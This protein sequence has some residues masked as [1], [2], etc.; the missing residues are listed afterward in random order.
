MT[1]PPITLDDIVDIA[2]YE[3]ERDERRA[4][5]MAA[6]GVRRVR[7]GPIVSAAF[8]NRATVIYQI[9]EM[10]RAE[11]IVHDDAIRQEIDVYSETLP[12]PAELSVTLFIELQGDAMLREW[13][14]K[15]IGIEDAISM[16]FGRAAAARGIGEEGRHTDE[17]TSA[18]QYVRFP[19][20]PD[21]RSVLAGGGPVTL[22]VDHPAYT[23][24]AELSEETCRAL[25]SD[26]DEISN[27][28]P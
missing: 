28:N 3:K 25:A 24:S 9:Q 19:L 4:A 2:R 17:V 15:L 7:V 20:T 8:E 21:Q 16:D 1:R 22:R 6:R 10:M 23:H 26:L 13:L 5:A 11:R 18:V 27:F 14:P 12:G